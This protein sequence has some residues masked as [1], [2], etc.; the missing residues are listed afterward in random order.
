MK[1]RT[2]CCLIGLLASC[3]LWAGAKDKKPL[4]RGMLVKMDSSGCG[5][6]EKGVAGIGG[7]M[8]SAGVERVTTEDK[9]CAEYVLRTDTMEYH[10]RPMDKK[11]PALLPV[12]HESLFR[13]A[14][15]RMYLRM[16]D[17]DTNKMH[18]YQVVS[19]KPLD[20][21]GHDAT[22]KSHDDDDDSDSCH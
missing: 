20:L 12:G 2:F 22:G 14:N 18:E 9:L 21:G 10:I 8:A 4:D 19:M 16:E 6:H 7:V 1:A 3:T 17:E 13:L 5:T 11:N 15:G